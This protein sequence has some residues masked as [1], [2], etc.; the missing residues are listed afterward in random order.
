MKGVDYS[1]LKRL[2]CV[3]RGHSCVATL[4]PGGGRGNLAAD[5]SFRG[6]DTASP[7]KRLNRLSWTTGRTVQTRKYSATLPPGGGRGNLAAGFSFGGTARLSELS[8]L[9]GS[10]HRADRARTYQATLPPGGGQ[11]NLA[12]NFFSHGKKPSR[13]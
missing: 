5:F 7:Q 13:V 9:S 12:A 2:H 4:P 1:R 10:P 6:T 11:G 3:P 8:E